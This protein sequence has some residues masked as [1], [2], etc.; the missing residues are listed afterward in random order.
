MHLK[1][2]E[3]VIGYTCISLQSIEILMQHFVFEREHQ[4][5]GDAVGP[6]FSLEQALPCVHAI[7]RS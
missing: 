5:V 3:M 2:C 4:C 6:P 7:T 1:E